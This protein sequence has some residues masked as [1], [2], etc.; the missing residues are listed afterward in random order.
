M[1]RSRQRKDEVTTRVREDCILSPTTFLSEM[2]K[3][4]NKFAE[5]RKRGI[6][7]RMMERLEDLDFADDICLLIQRWS[8][9]KTKLKKLKKDQ[10]RW[11]IK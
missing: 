5:G 4:M 8:D 9:T 10:Q 11:N 2:V 3:V 6:Q 7:W 1:S